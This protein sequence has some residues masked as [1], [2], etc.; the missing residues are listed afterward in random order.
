MSS[1]TLIILIA[2]VVAR[3]L[4]GFSDYSGESCVDPIWSDSHDLSQASLRL[5]NSET[6]RR[7]GTGW[8]SP[9]TCTPRNGDLM[10]VSEMQRDLLLPSGHR[11]VG[12]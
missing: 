5:L 7:K 1:A 8:S 9:S 12:T 3:I 2:A 4:V 11:V 6:M 10:R